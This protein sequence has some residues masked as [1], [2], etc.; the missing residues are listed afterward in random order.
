MKRPSGE[1]SHMSAKNDFMIISSHDAFSGSYSVFQ[2]F[3][4]A[5]AA[6]YGMKYKMDY[7]YPDGHPG[8]TAFLS[9]NSSGQWIE[10]E[11]CTRIANELGALLPHLEDASPGDSAR[12]HADHARQFIAGCRKAAEANEPL[13]FEDTS[14]NVFGLWHKG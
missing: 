1:D 11:S 7:F 3:R 12:S 2:R 10:P 5:V 6:A 14:N 8:L 13:T 4:L 9:Q